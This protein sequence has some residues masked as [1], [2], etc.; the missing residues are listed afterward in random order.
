MGTMIRVGA[1]FG[2]RTTPLEGSLNSLYCATSPTAPIRGQGRY[3]LPVANIDN[4]VDGWLE[5][6]AMNERLWKQSEEVM[7]R[8]Q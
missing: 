6:S 1:K 4:K 5:D 2:A 3:F 7:M 8:Y